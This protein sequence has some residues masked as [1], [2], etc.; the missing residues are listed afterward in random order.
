MRKN[1]KLTAAFIVVGL[2][3]MAIGAGAIYVI[4]YAGDF[5]MYVYKYQ[6]YMISI[7]SVAV[8][9]F[10]LACCFAAGFSGSYRNNYLKLAARIRDAEAKAVVT[11]LEETP[12][13][14]SEPDVEPPAPETPI[15]EITETPA[16]VPWPE[17]ETAAPEAAISEIDAELLGVIKLAQGFASEI[18]RIAARDDIVAAANDATDKSKVK[19]LIDEI[20]DI[21]F[22]AHLLSLNI[23]IESLNSA[24]SE[25]FEAILDEVQNLEN[26]S[27]SVAGRC[28]AVLGAAIELTRALTKKSRERNEQIGNLADRIDAEAEK[29]AEINVGVVESEEIIQLGAEVKY[30]KPSVVSPIDPGVGGNLYS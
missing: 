27:A 9:T 22:R 6:T 16:N 3:A 19:T 24:N 26:L 13:P 17:V 23:A 11:E 10:I 21:A 29:I 2:L 5:E 8:F 14:I 25:E 28:N 7:A 12:T 1:G 30:E 15:P 4:W 18:K 20:D